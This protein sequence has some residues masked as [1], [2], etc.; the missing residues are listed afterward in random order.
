MRWA[1]KAPWLT[2]T[3]HL[4]QKTP[5]RGIQRFFTKNN[6]WMQD[7]LNVFTLRGAMGAFTGILLLGANPW[8]GFP[9]FWKGVFPTDDSWFNYKSTMFWGGRVNYIKAFFIKNVCWLKPTPQR[10]RNN[11]RWHFLLCL[12]WWSL[13]HYLPDYFLSQTSK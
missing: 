4:K 11:E 2:F 9:L 13:F 1:I 12:F 3:E 5:L 8:V 6:H 10:C 7:L